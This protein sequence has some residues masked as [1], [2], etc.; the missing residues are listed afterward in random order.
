MINHLNYCFFNKTEA[1]QKLDQVLEPAG[2]SFS[3]P[4]RTLIPIPSV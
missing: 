1:E 4:R 2:T 3:P